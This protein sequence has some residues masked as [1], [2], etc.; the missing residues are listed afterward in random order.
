MHPR[1]ALMHK[2]WKVEKQQLIVFRFFGLNGIMEPN[3][4]E[5]KH[6]AITMEYFKTLNT[7]QFFEEI[8]CIFFFQISNV[9]SIGDH[10]VISNTT[11]ITFFSE[12]YF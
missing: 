12:F 7:R 5:C 6:E 4:N 2:K 9:N 11:Q 3:G 1:Q 8:L 10:D